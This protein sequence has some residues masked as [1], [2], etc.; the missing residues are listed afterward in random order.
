[1]ILDADRLRSLGTRAAADYAAASPFPH[2]VFTDL[3]DH[4]VLR[5]VAVEVD[6]LGRAGL[7]RP[8]DHRYQTKSAVGLEWEWGD[9]TRQLMHEL[10]GGVFVRFLESLTGIDG[11]VADPRYR[12][13]GVHEIPPGGALKVHADFSRHPDLPLRRRLNTLVYLNEDWDPGW[14]GNLELWDAD[15]NE[16][17]ETVVPE[18]GTVV[19][20]STTTTSFHGHPDPLDCPPDRCRRS[21]ATYYYTVPDELTAV[22]GDGGGTVWKQ[23]PGGSDRTLLDW[24]PPVLVDGVRRLRARRR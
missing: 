3:I 20:F 19:V 7:S 18:L 22:T 17:V 10:N 16:C 12:G 21:L 1:M 9:L 24:A 4:D 15:M 2:A 11:L 6:E 13:A 23:R 14:G 8:A 5:V